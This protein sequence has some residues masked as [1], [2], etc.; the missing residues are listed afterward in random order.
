MKPTRFLT[1]S[2][3]VVECLDKICDRSHK[4]Q[5][6]SGGKAAE[7]AFYPLPL[8]RAI[9]KGMRDTADSEAN[10]RDN[11]ME[12]NEFVNAFAET[13]GTVPMS[14]SQVY[15]YISNNSDKWRQCEQMS[16]MIPT[17]STVTLMN[18]Q[19]MC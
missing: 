7:A 17:S 1:T 8:I 5:H 6:L 2:Q 14:A 16:I 13:Q 15:S 18:I 3:Q 4:H 19:A 9:L 11:T 10:H 12:Q